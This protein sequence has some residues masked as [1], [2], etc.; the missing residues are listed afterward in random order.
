QLVSPMMRLR[1]DCSDGRMTSFI[2]AES[3]FAPLVFLI[4][5]ATFAGCMGLGLAFLRLLRLNLPAPFLQVVAVL[6]GIQLNS[7]AVQAIAMAHAATSAVLVAFCAVSLAGGVLGLICFRPGSQG[8]LLRGVPRIAIAI[9]IIACGANLIAAVVP[10]SKIDELHYHMLLPARIV[11]DQGLEFYRL[12]IEAAILPHMTYQ[13]FAAPLHA[14][15]F[16]D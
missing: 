4:G 7:V 9:A 3:Y 16:P 11:A 12:P 6:T 15:G 10:S 13:I 1:E 14:L 8:G 2:N 5:V